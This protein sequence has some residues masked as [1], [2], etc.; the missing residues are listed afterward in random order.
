VALH[1]E[2]NVNSPASASKIHVHVSKNQVSAYDTCNSNT[3]ANAVSEISK[4]TASARKTKSMTVKSDGSYNQGVQR[5]I[6]L[7]TKGISSPEQQRTTTFSYIDVRKIKP[8]N[9]NDELATSNT[10]VSILHPKHNN[11]KV[12]AIDGVDVALV[13]KD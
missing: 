13:K 7:K 1:H 2:E 8:I 11:N 12:G 10:K 6:S 9:D 4:Q 3:D 5:V